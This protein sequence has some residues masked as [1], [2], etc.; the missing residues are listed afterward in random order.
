[1]NYNWNWGVFF[2]QTPDGDGA[3]WEWIVA[4]LYWTLAD[5]R[6]R[7]GSSR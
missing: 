5:L 7:P 3:Y 6:A 2:Q 4:G 1:M